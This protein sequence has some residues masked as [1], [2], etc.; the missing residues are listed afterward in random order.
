MAVLFAFS[1]LFKV[2]NTKQVLLRLASLNIAFPLEIQN[3]PHLIN[4]EIV[5]K[6]KIFIK[7][8]KSIY[9]DATQTKFQ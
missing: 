9:C 2:G 1:I 7:S 4:G 3:F 6:P 8:I 5:Q